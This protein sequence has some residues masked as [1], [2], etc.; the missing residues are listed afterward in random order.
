MSERPILG[1]DPG[2][3]GGLAFLFSARV[4][5]VDI[6]VVDGEVDTDTLA[7]IV[8]SYAPRFAAIERVGAMPGQGVSSTFKFGTAYGAIRAVVSTLGVPSRRVTPQKWKK[9]FG[10]G[11][12]KE[13][14]R[15]RAIET[16]P[17]AKC[18]SRKKDHGRAEAALIAL[19]AREHLVQPEAQGVFS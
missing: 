7:E 18:F 4:E 10:L 19:Y 14:C 8:R 11:P 1:V 5:A 9:A 3:T 17:G 13:Q 12:D 15:A 16:W 2:I 6:P